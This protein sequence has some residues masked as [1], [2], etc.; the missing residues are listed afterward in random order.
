MKI[1]LT[2]LLP[3]V[4]A[5]AVTVPTYGADKEITIRRAEVRPPEMR[6]AVRVQVGPSQLEKENV[7]FLGVQ[8]APVSRTLAAQLGLPRDTGLVVVDVVDDS[9]AAAVLQEHDVLTK[10]DDQILVGQ[11]QLSVLIRHR[12]KDDEVTLTV[13]RGGR[14]LELKTKLGEREVPKPM[15]LGPGE[16][17]EAPGFRFFSL[18]GP[19]VARLEKMPGMEPGQVDEVIRMIG[20]NRG[21]W[22]ARPNIQVFRGRGQGATIL[23]LRQGNIVYSDSEGSLEVRAEKGQRQLTVKDSTGAVTFEGPVNTPEERE[24]LPSEVK[25]RLSRLEG[26]DLSLEPGE[27]FKAEGADLRPGAGLRRIQLPALPPPAAARRF[28]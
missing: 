21:D 11:Q 26:V 12:K 20:R 19:E 18:D 4:L 15:T 27:D 13:Y 3:A 1:Q 6:T 8:T 17:G 7:A 24:K 16:P 14:K 28:F 25:A 22:V 9:P 23:D 5:V 2:R 10:L